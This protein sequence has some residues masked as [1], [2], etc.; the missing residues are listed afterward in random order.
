MPEAIK[1]LGETEVELK[2]Y[3]GVSARLKV[4]VENAN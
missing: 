4:K 3:A 2:L 1:M